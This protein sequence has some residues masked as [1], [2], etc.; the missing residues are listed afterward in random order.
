MRLTRRVLLLSGIGGTGALVLGWSG[1]PPRGRLGRAELL[2][3]ATGEVALN[4]W[5]D[6]SFV[7][8]YPTYGE[9]SGILPRAVMGGG[10]VVTVDIGSYPEFESPLID[11]VSIGSGLVDQLH[12]SIEKLCA[13][14]PKASDRAARRQVEAQRADS[15]SPRSL[16]PRIRALL[17]AAWE[18]PR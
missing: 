12:A 13:S 18:A 2:P 4:G 16:Y 10:R 15:L 5:I 7:L 8:R 14:M 6:L 17:D 3:E 9:T 1:L 11:H